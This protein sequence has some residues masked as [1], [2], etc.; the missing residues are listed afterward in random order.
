MD[1]KIKQ[2]LIA[3]MLG[4]GG[5][6]KNDI[7]STGCKYKEYVD[8]KYNILKKYALANWYR[9]IPHN[10]YKDKEYHKLTLKKNKEITAICRQPLEDLLNSLDLFGLA[11]WFYD[12][13]SLHNKKDFYNLSTHAFSKTEHENLIIPRLKDFGLKPTLAI[14]R[15]LDGRILYYIRIN[16]KDGAEIINK[17][18]KKIPL[19]CYAYKT[20]P[21]DIMST[22]TEKS[23][24]VIKS[25]GTRVD[26][27]GINA[28][29]K[30]EGTCSQTIRKYIKS[31][32]PLKGTIFYYTYEFNDQPKGV[33]P[34]GSKRETSTDEDMVYSEGKPS[35]VG[36]RP[37]GTN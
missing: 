8:Y 36:E 31:G 15:K 3:S 27:T 28:A 7:F 30:G 32:L 11:I 22:L 5:M 35:A 12:D 13:G 25:D 4:D 20:R 14:E 23:I 9:F 26:Y 24:Y 6:S 34:S 19:S 16:K 33:G 21:Y 10:G 18:L 17:A 1:N 29:A 2:V 37:T